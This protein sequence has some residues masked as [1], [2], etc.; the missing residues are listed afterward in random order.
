[1]PLSLDPDHKSA[2]FFDR[3]KN[4]LCV[5]IRTKKN[6]PFFD[7]DE[8]KYSFSLI[9]YWSGSKNARFYTIWINKMLPF[10][11]SGTKIFNPDEK[12]GRFF[13]SLL[14]IERDFL[15]FDPDQKTIPFFGCQSKIYGN[16]SDLDEKSFFLSR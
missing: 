10:L 8:K 15:L 11:S 13:Y 16:F 6:A 1:M 4:A 12:N 3:S 2:A 7:L 5:L 9:G 14:F